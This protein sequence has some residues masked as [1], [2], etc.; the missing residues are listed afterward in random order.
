VRALAGFGDDD[1]DHPEGVLVGRRH[2]HGGG[3]GRRLVGVRHRIDAQPSG[4][5]TE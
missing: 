5:I 4:L 1:V 2:P 3:R